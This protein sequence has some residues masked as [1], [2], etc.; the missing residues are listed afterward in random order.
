VEYWEHLAVRISVC[1]VYLEQNEVGGINFPT[2]I[3]RIKYTDDQQ[4]QKNKKE[5]QAL[6]RP[7]WPGGT[8]FPRGDRR[9]FQAL[10]QDVESGLLSKNR[11]RT[12][13]TP[14]FNNDR[15]HFTYSFTLP[16]VPSEKDEHL[17]VDHKKRVAEALL[18]I[19]DIVSDK[20]FS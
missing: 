12:S 17:E 15:K 1:Q 3:L 2:I 13:I 6:F 14:T 10:Q 4:V 19:E 5:H 8:L 20:L 9:C 11:T 7:R 16:S 18:E